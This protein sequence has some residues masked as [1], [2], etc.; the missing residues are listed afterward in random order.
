[1]TWKGESNVYY[2]TQNKTS[3][4]RKK[5]TLSR[6]GNC[7]RELGSGTKD[8][9]ISLL[10]KVYGIQEKTAISS[11]IVCWLRCKPICAQKKR[12]CYLFRRQK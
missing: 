11:E 9:K 1:M 4:K 6:S 3:K 10:K 5:A 8:S 7:L 12:F 2:I